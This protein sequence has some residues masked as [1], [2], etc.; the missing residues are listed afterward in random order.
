MMLFKRGVGRRRRDEGEKRGLE[1]T[2]SQSLPV[3]R[4]RLRG[5]KKL[6]TAEAGAVAERIVQ[7]QNCFTQHRKAL[8]K[9]R[10][11]AFGLNQ[12]DLAAILGHRK[13]YVSELVNGVRPLSKSDVILINRVLWIEVDKLIEPILNEEDAE[14][15]RGVIKRLNKPNLKLKEDDLHLEVA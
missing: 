11:K 5:G 4:G 2:L 15:I 10:L 13:S 9:D 6:F 8:I 14:R 3:V 1:I 12:N 7:F